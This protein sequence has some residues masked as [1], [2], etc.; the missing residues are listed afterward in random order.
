[1]A[2][3]TSRVSRV[4]IVGPLAQFADAYGAELRLGLYP[5]VD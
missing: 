5:V 3:P 4:L 1:M 2:G